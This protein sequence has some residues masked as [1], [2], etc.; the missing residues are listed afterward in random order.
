[1]MSRFQTPLILSL[2]TILLAACAST[3]RSTDTTRTTS[4]D[5]PSAPITDSDAVAA[6][7]SVK[8]DLTASDTAAEI[9]AI[10]HAKFPTSLSLCPAMSISNA[11][12]ATTD[13]IILKYR[14]IATV[15]D[16]KIAVAP[17]EA[18][19]FSSGFGPRNGRLHK[20]I[21]LHAPSAVDIYAAADG[22][23]R[24]KV[25]RDDYGNMLVIEHGDG[26]FARYAH[27]ERFA[28]GI[29]IGDTVASGQTIGTMGNTASYEIPRHLHYEVLT[30][31]YG[32]LTG[33]FGLT[34]V[35]LLEY[36]PEN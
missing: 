25:Y 1:M 21:D 9:I 7:P 36:L 6:P 24:E 32:T 8:P 5:T 34:P 29:A 2:A 14:V 33:S 10:G 28:D 13:N 16:V 4:A 18:G 11:P 26:V 19:C 17:V 3:D 15:N 35:D 27:L 31:N 23:V 22:L 30:G 12:A 20:G